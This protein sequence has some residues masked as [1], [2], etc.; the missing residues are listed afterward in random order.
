M[1]AVR[2]TELTCEPFGSTKTGTCS[3]L[4]AHACTPYPGDADDNSH[5]KET[6]RTSRTTRRC[7]DEFACVA[8]EQA[9]DTCNEKAV[10]SCSLKLVNCGLGAEVEALPV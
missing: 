3:L 9:V 10:G 7:E 4:V 2:T 8:A 5:N 1:E 6:A